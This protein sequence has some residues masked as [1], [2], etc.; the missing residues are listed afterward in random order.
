MVVDAEVFYWTEVGMRPRG[1]GDAYITVR[2]AER[3]LEEAD[4][5]RRVAM[6]AAADGGDVS[7]G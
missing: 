6:V 5:R 2:E 4:E 3:L 1:Y 7:N